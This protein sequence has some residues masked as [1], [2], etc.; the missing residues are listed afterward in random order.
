MTPA[1]RAPLLFLAPLLLP[2]LLQ[3]PAPLPPPERTPARVMTFH[4]ASWLEREGREVEQ[5]PAEIFRAMGLKGGDVVADLGCGTG[6]FARRMARIVSPR[7]KVYAVDIQPEMLE[8]LRDYMKKEKVVGVEPVLGTETDPK[9]PAGGLDWI[10]MVDVYHEFQQPK[11]MLEAIRRSLKPTGRVALVE[12]R[13]EGVSA[14]HIRVEHRMSVEQVMAEWTPAGFRLVERLDFLPSQHLFIFAAMAEGAGPGLTSSGGQTSLAFPSRWR[15]P[16]G[17]ALA[18]RD[19]TTGVEALGEPLRVTGIGAERRE[20]RP[21]RENP[22]GSLQA[23]CCRAADEAPKGRCHPEDGAAAVGALDRATGARERASGHE[24]SDEGPRPC[25]PAVEAM[26]LDPN[27]IDLLLPHHAD[28]ARGE[29]EEAFRA[30][31]EQLTFQESDLL[32]IVPVDGRYFDGSTHHG[33]ACS[34]RGAAL[35]REERRPEADG[36]GDVSHGYLLKRLFQN[37]RSVPASRAFHGAASRRR[38]SSGRVTA[39]AS[40]AGSSS[41][42]HSARIH[43]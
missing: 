3:A 26:Q 22:A 5:R 7:G 32:S 38:A 15:A 20:V 19:E 28:A 29:H 18:G 41:A 27:A 1:A 34:R 2:L 16:A 23:Q 8:L 42:N 10:L 35:D 14:S 43:S 17:C 11:V 40:M 36:C 33:H 4:G 6:W 31:R 12:Y 30:H 25:L 9:L 13:L 24:P 37:V 21:A 39:S